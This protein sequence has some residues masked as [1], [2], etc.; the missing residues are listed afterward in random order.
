MRL[1]SL[2]LRGF[3][4]FADPVTI[5][6]G[7]G[8]NAIVGPNGSGKSNVVDAVSWVLGTQSPRLL[9]LAR[10]DEVV[11]QG[12]ARRAPLGRAEVELVFEDPEGIGGLGLGEISLMRRVER[13]GEA[14]YRVNGRP[15]RLGDVVDVLQAA[16]IGRTQHVIV[17]QG[18]I[19]AL[20][21]A[22]G[23]VL[24][25]M[26]EDA[27]RVTSLRRQRAAILD[28]LARA[29][30]ALAETDRQVKDLR[31]QRRPLV[32]QVERL[33]RRRELE[34]RWRALALARARH[35]LEERGGAL[36]LAEGH[37]LAMAQRVE[38]LEG[39]LRELGEE[40]SDPPVDPEPVAA[41]LRRLRRN[42]AELSRAL[43]ALEGRRQ[44]AAAIER[45]VLERERLQAERGELM[46]TL[47]ELEG[48]AERLL[49]ERS[50]LERALEGLA[51]IPVDGA[52]AALESV[53]Q[54][55]A[56]LEARLAERARAR[57]AAARR[58][59]A[60]EAQRARDELRLGTVREHLAA[61]AAQERVL[62]EE[63]S[64]LGERRSAL[65]AVLREA[66]DVADRTAE[67]RSV[68]LAGV[69]AAQANREH[70]AAELERL[71]VTLGESSGQR[72]VID[73]VHPAPG[74]GELVAAALGEL[75]EAWVVPSVDELPATGVVN[76]V[77]LDAAGQDEGGELGSGPGLLGE[78]LR[79][80]RIV[81]S[82]R[83]A[84]SDVRGDEPAEE[85]LVDEDGWVAEGRWVRRG[86]GVRAALRVRARELE[87]E[88]GQADADVARAVERVRRAEAAFEEARGAVDKARRELSELAE[89]ARAL[90]ASVA[91]LT[92]ERS[93]LE[94]E[95][96][97]LEARLDAGLSESLPRE[98]EGDE[99]DDEEARRRLA[100]ITEEERVRVAKLAD[101]ERRAA[102]AAESRRSI[103]VRLVEVRLEA[104][105]EAQRAA[106]VRE[107]LEGL[108][109]AL[110]IPVEAASRGADLSDLAAQEARG[111]EL[112]TKL[113]ALATR[114]EATL[115]LLLNEGA[116]QRAT[117]EAHRA[118]RQRLEEEL[119][120]A[121][122]AYV[123]AMSG[124]EHARARL[125]AEQE[126]WQLR[127]RVDVAEIEHAPLPQ[128]VAPHE[129]AGALHA[130][131][132]E[133]D[134]FGEVNGIAAEELRVLDERL[135]DLER[136]LS[137]ARGVRD[138]IRAGLEELEDTMRSRLAETVGEVSDAFGR[139]V[140]EL[141]S[142]GS[143]CVALE[144][145]VEPLESTVRVE[146]GLPTKRVHRL[147][148]LSGGERSLVG[149][150]LLFAMLE[151]RPVP[152]L[153]LDEADAALDEHNLLRFLRLLERYVARSQVLMVTH[154]RRTMEAAHV[155]LGVSISPAGVSTVVRH[156]LSSGPPAGEDLKR[157]LP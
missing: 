148:L 102:I 43:S 10:M 127:L 13:G 118:A 145:G 4:S 155:L 99:Q 65:E 64:G 44:E 85:V 150:A 149:L 36:V 146:V 40:P 53:R 138:R 91:A 23:D 81:P 45:R 21:S 37:A 130:I 75:A 110:E 70:L 125:A 32:A 124:L 49:V 16:N 101:L 88:L 3:K 74:M 113:E 12:S 57:E 78:R 117:R 107:R 151:V 144:D 93:R 18:E 112:G 153:V 83:S 11:Y 77:V 143:G 133:L 137:E 50:E 29:E 6:F 103:E 128:G 52:R 28:N 30:E 87:A 97:G 123:D 105:R 142:G 129:L 8:L 76:A 120:R 38:Q 14:T 62:A 80:V 72:L 116:R 39:A 139:L 69:S 59:A 73:L 5:R 140:A 33:G 27:S 122:G 108:E 24:R 63:L 157:R 48:R 19:D 46:H 92:D 34:A 90:G 31:R 84:L 26:L 152:F 89:R 2:R 1:R 82:V 7:P 51:P 96:A 106:A 20:A 95:R 109:R 100:R 156:D 35:A 54:E 134:A 9:R 115:E 132:V 66:E 71:R 58:R 121:R 42:E 67:E 98:V 17:S 114:L 68:A 47:E 55:R 147:Q 136:V 61:L 141:F 15:V 56:G 41:A 154:Q 60:L 111:R 25:R 104:A 79:R 126:L 119:A 131:E 22:S 94:L 135:V 86:A